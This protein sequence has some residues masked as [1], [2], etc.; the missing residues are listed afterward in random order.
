MT[1]C[2]ADHNPESCLAPIQG[3]GIHRFQDGSRN[4]IQ[5]L[6]EVLKQEPGNLAARWLLNV[7]SMTVGDYPEKVPA[8]WLVPPGAFASEH[9]IKRF[10]DLA[11]AVGLDP[12]KRS[13]G[14]IV[15]DFDGDGNLDVMSS[16][17]GLR[18]QLRL[19]HNNGDGLFTERTSEAGLLG[20]VGGLNLIQAD[21]NN[22]GFPDVL[23][24]RGGWMGPEGHFP[25]SL[26]RNNRDGTFED[27]TEAAGLLSL[28]P[29]QTAVWFDYDNDGWIDLFIGNE[30]AV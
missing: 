5:I 24:L 15:E 2:V 16:S 19:F 28:K 29:S 17:V 12:M 27:V 6:T 14:S 8:Q 13:G 22:D 4:A 1:N 21:Y 23:V 7:A 26:L 9:D 30:S 11:G 25:K 18:D 10:R 3:R 20:E